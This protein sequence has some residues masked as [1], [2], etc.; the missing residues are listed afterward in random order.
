MRELAALSD[1]V[2][3]R[4]RGASR[5][6]LRCWRPVEQARRSCHSSGW[7]V[8]RE[9]SQRRVLSIGQIDRRL[10]MPENAQAITNRFVA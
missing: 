6:W 9:R 8:E 3:F 4:V 10:V 1:R 7:L 2:R 5:R